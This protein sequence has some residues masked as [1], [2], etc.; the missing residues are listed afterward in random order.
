M[1]T[2]GEQLRAAR[3]RVGLSQEALANRAA[4][5]KMTVLKLEKGV[6]KEPGIMAICRLMWVLKCRFVFEYGGKTFVLHGDKDYGTKWYEEH[7][8]AK[9]EQ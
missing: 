2:F 5:T 4:M 7:K 3:K 8:E 9:V 6:T 1:Q